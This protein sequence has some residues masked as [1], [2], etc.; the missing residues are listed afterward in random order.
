MNL[1][2]ALPFAALI[3]VLAGLAS[4]GMPGFSGFVAE[5]QV[6]IGA[7]RMYPTL[8]VICGAGI[9]IAVA[10][11]LRAI[12]R[13]FFSNEPPAANVHALPP[14]TIPERVGSIM[15]IAC[16]LIVGLYPRLLLDIINPSWDSTLMSRLLIR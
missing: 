9:I 4:M 14:I 12:H 7:W 6:L 16:S 5:F 15:L 10:Y 3:F 13:S 11:T 1:G 2:Q 8:A